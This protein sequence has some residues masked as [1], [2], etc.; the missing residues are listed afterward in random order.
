MS[1]VACLANAGKLSGWKPEKW[2]ETA[3]SMQVNNVVVVCL[4]MVN[5]GC[6]ISLMTYSTV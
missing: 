5:V 6:R 4:S 2:P 1:L 3:R